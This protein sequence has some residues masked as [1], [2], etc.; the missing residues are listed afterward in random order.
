MKP[1][2]IEALSDGIFAIVMT[3][4]VLELKVP[5]AETSYDLIEGLATLWPKF[6]SFIISF[7]ILG[8][9]WGGHHIQ[10]GFV[11]RANFNF[12]WLNI[13]F[14]LSISLIPFSTALLGEHPYEQIALITYGIN[15]II[16]ALLLYANWKY[17]QRHNLVDTAEISAELRRNA[18]HKILLPPTLYFIA[19]VLSFV[20]TRL[21]LLLF[22]AGP[23][24]YFIPVSTRI[25]NAITDPFS[26]AAA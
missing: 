18:R 12:M 8:I 3:L 11:K 7:L 21:S 5:V 13:I 24:I 16:C 2:R 6:V 10:F 26:K 14:L 15:L 25:W 22:I 19:I 9:Y 1:S 4:L 20:N 17:A 23:L